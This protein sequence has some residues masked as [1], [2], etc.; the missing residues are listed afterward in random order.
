MN[1]VLKTVLKTGTLVD[2]QTGRLVDGQTG[3]QTDRQTDR[4][5][6]VLGTRY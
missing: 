1:T 3:R 5:V 2:W 4:L 6:L